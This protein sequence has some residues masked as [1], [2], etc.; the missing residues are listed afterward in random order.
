MEMYPAHAYKSSVCRLL[1]PVH[2]YKNTESCGLF[3]CCVA[4]KQKELLSRKKKKEHIYIY[5]Y[6]YIYKTL[7]QLYGEKVYIYAL[8]FFA[9]QQLFSFFFPGSWHVMIAIWSAEYRKPYISSHTFKP[10]ILSHTFKPCRPLGRPKRWPKAL[11]LFVFFFFLARLLTALRPAGLEGVW[12]LRAWRCVALKGLKAVRRRAKK[13]EGV[14]PLRA[15][16]G[17]KGLKGL[18]GR[19][20]AG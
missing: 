7:F 17:L 13:L 16:K 8:F 15:L 1:Y 6:I 9:T 5:I 2:V 18:L 4:Q 11:R 19:R 14:W 12:P 10:Y 20:K 3:S